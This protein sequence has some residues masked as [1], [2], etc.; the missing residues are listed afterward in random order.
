VPPPPPK[1]SFYYVNGK[2]VPPEDAMISVRD[3]G[4]LRGFGCFDYFRTYSGKPV[5]LMLNVQRL[6]SS[7]TQ[8]GLDFPWKD[9]EFASI[10]KETLKRNHCSSEL[11]WGIRII[12]SGGCSASNIIPDSFPTLIIIPESIPSPTN[13][14][15]QKGVKVITVDLNRVFP[16]SKTTNYITAV[17]AQQKARKQNA[18]EA[19]YT[20]NGLVYE[21]T[22]S[23]IFAFYKNTLRT[24]GKDIL[25]GITRALILDLL[26][27]TPEQRSPFQVEIGEMSYNSLL[28]ADEVFITSANKRILPV[29]NVDD[30]IIGSGSTGKNTKT[31]LQLFNRRCGVKEE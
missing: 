14:M 25:P 18:Q 4:I 22:T 3:L 31:L 28:K 8:I 26:K 5:T 20:H 6:R 9:E 2:F 1:A 15:I 12:V 21:G 27:T 7:C 29:V 24:P 13:E 10:I 17:V 19:I 11:D 23:N 30:S 16:T